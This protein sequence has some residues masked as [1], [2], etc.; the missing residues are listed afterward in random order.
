MRVEPSIEVAI[1]LSKVHL[2]LLCLPKYKPLANQTWNLEG[3]IHFA[4]YYGQPLLKLRG[5]LSS[6]LAEYSLVSASHCQGAKKIKMMPSFCKGNDLRH[7]R[8]TARYI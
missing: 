1:D 3:L 4:S 7:V 6:R 8:Q 5:N 2:A